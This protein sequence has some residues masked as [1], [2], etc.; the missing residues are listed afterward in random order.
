M[1]EN[2][3]ESKKI[4]PN[5][6]NKTNGIKT[7]SLLKL[8]PKFK[9]QKKKVNKQLL[10][11]KRKLFKKISKKEKAKLNILSINHQE[12]FSINKIP[13]SK[14]NL[15]QNENYFKISIIY[16]AAIVFIVIVSKNGSIVIKIIAL[17]VSV[18][19]TA[20]KC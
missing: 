16:I 14:K 15:N 11:T 7:I 17:C 4:S 5:N 10:G 2:I 8:I 9:K 3:S 12:N 18:I 20:K 6:E 19:L 1:T 13:N